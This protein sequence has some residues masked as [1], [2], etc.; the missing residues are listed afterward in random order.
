MFNDSTIAHTTISGVPS[1][2]F[3]LNI[4][5]PAAVIHLIQQDK[6]WQHSWVVS[7]EEAFEIAVTSSAWGD[8]SYS[9]P[10][11]Q[12]PTL[13]EDELVDILEHDAEH[14]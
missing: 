6:E 13:T 3:Q 1:L 5:C 7:F 12:A 9:D 14:P 10:N 4:M 11:E 2:E 8:L